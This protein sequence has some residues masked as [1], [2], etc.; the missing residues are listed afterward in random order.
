MKDNNIS[1]DSHLDA[2]DSTSFIANPS[3]DSLIDAELPALVA[4][5]KLLHA[6]PE[7]SGQEEKT[8]S[9]VAQ[10]LRSL[11]Y[12]VTEGIGKY[13]QHSWPGYGIVALMQNGAGPTVLVRAD[14]DALPVEEK[15]GLPYASQARAIYR[16]GKDVAVMHACGHDLHVTTLL[17]TARLLAQMKGAWQGSV[18][19]IGQPG[20]EGAG[21]A[22]AMIND[23]AYQLCPQPD[24]ALSLHSTLRLEAGSIGYVPGNFMASLSELEVTVRGV[25]S[26]GSA[27]ECGKDPIIMAAQLILALQSIVSRETNPFDPAVVT[28]GSIHGGTASNI[29]P[30]EVQLQLSIRTYDNRVRDRIIAS[31]ERIAK[32]VALT[33]GVPE[34]CAPIVTVKTMHP[35]N[36]NDPELT[37]RVA[38]ALKQEFG[39]GRIVRSDP[40]MASEDFGSWGLG[41]RIPTCMLWL[42]AADP[43]QFEESR[44]TGVPLP[45][46]HSPFY[47]P[48][49]EPTVR[50]GVKAMS[51]AVLDLLAR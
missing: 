30:E 37:E 17:G 46:H 24:Y 26:H 15:T 48:L 10:E 9:L 16:D 39:E 11:G 3:L 19:L 12:A 41:G 6:T 44:Q 4:I 35:A 25:G 50:A 2:S 32:G 20:E 14:M 36:Y 38:R 28:V 7:L 8:S 49:P 33:A 34:E 43:V 1:S 42:G 27:P 29:I 13:E 47:A 18:V 21:G 31:V 22:Q 40:V 23:G 45:S 51:A 5:Y